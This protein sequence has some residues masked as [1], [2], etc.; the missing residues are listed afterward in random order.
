MKYKF[1]DDITDRKTFLKTDVDPV[2]HILAENNNN[3]FLKMHEFF[4]YDKFLLLVSGFMGT[5]KSSIIDYF[6][7]FLKQ[8]TIVLKYNCYE[9][10]NLEDLLLAFFEKFKVL[11]AQNIIREPKIRSDNFAQK[12][13]SYFISVSA[14]IVVVIDSFEQVLKNNKTEIIDFL[15]HLSHTDKVKVIIA[16]RTFDLNDFEKKFDYTKI[17]VGALDKPIFEKY[18]K[19][20]DIKTIGPV[21][22]ELYKHTRGYFLY[23]SLALKIMQIRGLSMYEFLDGYSKSFLSYNDFI[24]REALALIDPVSG[25]L[26]RFLTIIRHPVNI[27]LLKMLQLYDEFKIKIFVETLILSVDENSIYLKDYYKVIAENSIPVNVAVKIHKSCVDLYNTQLPLKPMERALLISRATMRSEI[28][29][30]STFL[31]KKPVVKPKYII[32]NGLRI[33]QPQEIPPVEQEEK[34]DIKNISFIFESEESEASIMNGIAESINEFI[35]FTDEQIKQ[36][37][38]EN[39]MSLV[40]L[41]NLARQQENK[42]NFKRVV[43]IY[44]RILMMKN[45]QNYLKFLPI[46]Y[47]RLGAAYEKLSDWFNSLKYYEDAL[48][49]YLTS[50]DILKATDIKLL[51]A[52]VYYQMFK[53]DKAKEVLTE[54]V[55]EENLPVEIYIKSFIKLADISD[56]EPQTAYDYLKKALQFVE[57]AEDEVLLAELYYKLGILSDETGEVKQAVMCY[58]N[59]VELAEDKNPYAS[60]AYTNLAAIYEESDAKDSAEKFYELSLEL[61]E[62]SGNDNG[63]YHS[64]MKLASLTRRKN[65]EKALSYYEKAYEMAEKLKEPLYKVSTSMALGDFYNL[66]LKNSSIALEKYFI[67]RYIGEGKIGDKNMAKINKRIEDVKAIL[68]ESKFDEIQRRFDDEIKQK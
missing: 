33:D 30:H 28:E 31:P 54:L 29:F 5:G 11:E 23:V 44:Q 41:I 13:N 64:S 48:K 16:G 65:P 10:T 52:N 39:N 53:R 2:T 6:A 42:F 4:M 38:K 24:L 34:Q 3:Q 17:M 67:A 21:S 25:H 35:T 55:S 51:I 20:Y 56:E 61:D 22:D 27:N 46:V 8:E 32:E 60:G 7:T 68:G 15:K 43:M 57:N 26:F 1:I 59:C 18:L 47:T 36:I 40:E 14:P 62:K 58:K 45:D 50:S 19:L 37:E 63:I 12:I 9:T 49:I 66:Y